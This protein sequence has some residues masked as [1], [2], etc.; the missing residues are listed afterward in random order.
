MRGA[1]IFGAVVFALFVGGCGSESTTQLIE[2]LKAPDTLTR[3]KAVRTLPQRQGEGALIVPALMEALKDEEGDVRRGAA[4]GLELFGARA[5]DAVPALERCLRDRES[6]VR[7][8]AAQ[9]IQKIDP[10][11]VRKE[12]AR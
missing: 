8:A 10:G 4:Q 1:R 9:A 6:S 5:R 12:K 7:K 2:K 11:A 3:L